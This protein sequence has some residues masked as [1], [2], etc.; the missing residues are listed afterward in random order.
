MTQQTWQKHSEWPLIVAAFAFLAAYSILV[1]VD[2]PSPYA[3][4]LMLVIW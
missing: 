2:P 4:V 3:D 1:I